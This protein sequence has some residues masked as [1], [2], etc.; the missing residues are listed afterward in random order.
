MLI[1]WIDAHT[2]SLRIPSPNPAVRQ[3]R[4]L[5][6]SRRVYMFLSRYGLFSVECIVIIIWWCM[7]KMVPT[8]VTVSSQDV[9]DCNIL[10]KQVS[11]NPSCWRTT[12]R[13]VET[14]RTSL[15]DVSRL[16]RRYLVTPATSCPVERL[17]SVGG[18]VDTVRR[19]SLSSDN[20]T[21]VVFMHEALPLLRK[22]RTDRIVQELLGT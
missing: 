21:L 7:C 15:P 11:P 5:R 3:T 2:E 10:A 13:V 18:Q 8:P 12:F 19:T 9:V 20:L 1:E 14:T 22:I 4:G 6:Y 16:A 17:F